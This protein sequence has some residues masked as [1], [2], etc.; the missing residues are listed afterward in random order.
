MK[1]GNLYDWERPVD[2]THRHPKDTEASYLARGLVGF[3][4]VAPLISRGHYGKVVRLA[5]AAQI[6][7]ALTGMGMKHKDEIMMTYSTVRALIALKRSQSDTPSG[8]P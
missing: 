7:F 4:I 6:A 5:S 1:N 8:T 3:F 2:L